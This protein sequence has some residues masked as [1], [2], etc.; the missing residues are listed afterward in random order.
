MSSTLQRTTPLRVLFLGQVI[1]R[2]GIQYL[3]EVARLLRGE[4]I[5]F[6]I[7]G[8]IGNSEE[9]VK[10][11]PLNMS[12][13]GPISRDKAPECFGNADLFA[14]TQLEAMAYGLPVIT[15]PNC[16]QVVTDGVY[17]MIVPTRDAVALAGAIRS[18]IKDPVR[19]QAM[20]LATRAKVSQFSLSVLGENLRER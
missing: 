18:L 5:H 16:G 13:H 20:S 19:L 4:K 1:L 12:F 10:S 6:D 14:L 17:G 11:A 9:A 3:I 2:K 15:T 7:V 8:P